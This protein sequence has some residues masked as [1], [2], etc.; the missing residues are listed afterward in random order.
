MNPAEKPA[1]SPFFLIFHLRSP[2]NMQ[3]LSRI[4]PPLMPKMFEAADSIGTLHFARFIVL[5]D[6]TLAFVSEYDGTF[7]DYIMDFAKFL[8]P[9]STRSSSTLITL[10]PP[11]W[12]KTPR[13]C[14]NGRGATISIHLLST[15]PIQP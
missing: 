11:R 14:S 10:R 7:D 5:G 6:T 2:S 1:Q 15:A 13:L 8:G 3:A 12:R 9:S 4:L